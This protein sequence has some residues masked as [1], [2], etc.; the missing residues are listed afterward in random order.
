M[1]IDTQMIQLKTEDLILTIFMVTITII[2]N[3][4]VI[5]VENLD[6]DR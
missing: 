5:N 4:G 2:N 3:G 1:G 6:R